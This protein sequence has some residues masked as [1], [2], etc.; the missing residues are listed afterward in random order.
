VRN[1]W[2]STLDPRIP[3]DAKARGVT[4]HS[5]VIIEACRPFPWLDKFPPTSALSLEEARAIEE[6]WGG[7]L[8]G[9][10]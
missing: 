5:K 6:K 4:S 10:G 3:A 2:S 1:A 7:V 8:K 9:S